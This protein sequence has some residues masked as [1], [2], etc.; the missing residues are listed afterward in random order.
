[1][2]AKC[3]ICGRTWNVSA[4]QCIPKSGYICPCC[5]TRDKLINAGIIK[6]EGSEDG[7]AKGKALYVRDR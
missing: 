5:D 1:M 2:T 7:K 3:R 6:R 4:K